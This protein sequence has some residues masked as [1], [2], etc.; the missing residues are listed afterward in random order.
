MDIRVLRYF[1]TVA[2]EENIT[3]AAESLHITQPSLS[4]QLME[5]EQELGKQL[6]VRGKRK[7]TL[8]DDG[9]LLRKR[10]EEI[11]ALLEKTEQELSADT[12]LGGKISIGGLPGKRVL[13]A[14]AELRAEHPDVSFDFYSGDACE[15]I[16][17]LDHGSLDFAVL[18]EPVDGV[19]YDY[20]SLGER[21]RWGLIMPDNCELAMKPAIK[22]EDLCS[23]PLILHKRVGLQRTIEHWAQTDLDHMN[24]AA[25]YNVLNG[26]PAALVRSGLGYVLITDDH[27]PGQLG[28]GLCFRR[29]EPPLESSHA[30]IRKRHAVLSKPAEAFLEKVKNT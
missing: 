27:L 14:A 5:L 3:R 15:I 29:L 6:L 23:V 28:S 25:T 1:L 10:A 18:L 24:V 21:A 30:L 11:V 12:A 4:K 16:E 13:Q 8:T 7:L 2:R 22:R 19:K 20:V 9:V 17:R 26:D